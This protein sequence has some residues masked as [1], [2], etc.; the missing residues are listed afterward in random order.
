VLR[1]KTQ[2]LLASAPIPDDYSDLIGK[3]EEFIK[4][5]AV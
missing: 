2:D 3:G 1:E 4:K 5:F